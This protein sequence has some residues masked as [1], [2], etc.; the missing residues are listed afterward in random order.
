MSIFLIEI[1]KEK[2]MNFAK[3]LIPLAAT[4][5]FVGCSSDDS[6]LS[7]ASSGDEGG[8][9]HVSVDY[10]KGRTMNAKIGRGIS[11]GN[12]WESTGKDMNQDA[13]WG[14]PILDSDFQVVKDAGFN[15]VRLPVRWNCDAEVNAPY[16]IDQNRLAG[17]LEDV[18]IINSLGMVAIVNFHHY[19]THNQCYGDGLV[20]AA[21]NIKNDPDTYALEKERF[22]A[23]WKQVATALNAFPDDMVVLEI[24]NEPNGIASSATINDMMLSAYNVI[25][26][27]APGKTIMF[28]G[29]GYSKF[30]EIKKLELPQDGNIIVSGHYYEPYEF[31][32]QGTAGDQYPCGAKIT[33]S[34]LTNIA[35]EFKSY[36]D[37][38]K[39]YFPDS[40]GIHSVPVNMGEFG[41]VGRTGSQCGEE[42]PSEAM[43]AQWTDYVI[44]AA[45]SYGISWQYWAYG[46]TSGF[47]AYDQSLEAW[48]PEMKA[49]FDKYTSK[50]FSQQ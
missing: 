9:T 22:L 20:T 31:T 21:Q 3:F 25:R 6:G 23:M 27:A 45:E 47:Q 36:I 46:K 10:S 40:D 11:M 37:T 44:R 26:E 28:E 19:E 34:D 43:R 15:S 18:S 16:T 42:A 1:T 17:V 29:N 4:L 48:M 41:G 30:A 2:L 13:G 38:I 7:K 12:S 5:S 49:I 35:R 33:S 39:V 8:T 24:L 14:N 32:H 50:P